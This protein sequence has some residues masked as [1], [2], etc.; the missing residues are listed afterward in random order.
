MRLVAAGEEKE[1]GN[2]VVVDAT[3]VDETGCR[4][5]F[6]LWRDDAKLAAANVG[7]IFYAYD[8]LVKPGSGH[9]GQSVLEK[10][11]MLPTSRIHVPDPREHTHT[12]RLLLTSDLPTEGLRDM[13][14]FHTETV[15]ADPEARESAEEAVPKQRA[16]KA[17]ADSAAKA[18]SAP[19]GKPEAKAKQL[20]AAKKQTIDS[21]T[22][23]LQQEAG[24]QFCYVLLWWLD[25]WQ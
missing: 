25:C 22:R 23:V 6:G 11:S 1:H 14:P 13:A 8:V 17:K 15:A 18:Q 2:A 7:K 21:M 3:F 24:R 9:E 5:S 10:L 16:A 4:V 19:K 20:A 12:A